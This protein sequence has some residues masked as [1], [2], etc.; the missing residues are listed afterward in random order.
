ML[1]RSYLETWKL[2]IES[3]LICLGFFQQNKNDFLVPKIAKAEL[4]V[5]NK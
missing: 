1:A 5:K 2:F 3:R 4:T